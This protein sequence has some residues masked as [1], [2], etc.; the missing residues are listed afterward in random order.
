MNK[1]FAAI[2]RAP[3]RFTTLAIIA[4]AVIVPAFVM[5][6]GPD[7]ATFT[8]AHPA[9]YVTF[10]SITDNPSVGDERNFLRIKEA[11][12]SNVYGK[13]VAL[14]PG[15]TYQVSMYYHNNAASNLNDSGVGVAKDVKARIQM[16]A[17]V[18][19]GGTATVTGFVNS[20]NANPTSV[21]DSSTATAVESVALRYVQG[22]AKVTSNGAVNGAT[23]PDSLFTTGTN[24]GYD[25]LD[26]ILKGCNQFAGYVTFSFVA[27][28]PNFTVQKQISVDGGKTWTTNATSSPDATV[29]YRVIYTNTGTTNQ[30]N[31]SV[32]DTLPNGVSYVTGSTLVANAS[33]NGSYKAT[34]DGITANGLAIGSYSPAANAYVKF[35]AKL[36]SNTA[37]PVCGPN[38]LTNVA[39]ITT[40]GGYKESSAVVTIN[41]TCAPGKINVCDLSTKKVVTIDESAF[42]SK[43]YTKDLSVCTPPELPHTGASE[44]I[45]AFA[46]LGALIASVVYYVRSRRLAINL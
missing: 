34:V 21:W 36:P 12:D 7:R 37:L 30:D 40:S 6:Y 14:T 15:K 44:N 1:L 41:K 45:V 13:T 25:S 9:P 5:A 35:S 33:T 22:S 24:L 28:Q 31:I 23:L 42:D 29:L 32:R 8:F 10:N 43:K 18:A 2:K 27:V 16:P 17:T 38:T 39:R 3:K 46:G 4:A 20:S 26:G 11:G 19:A